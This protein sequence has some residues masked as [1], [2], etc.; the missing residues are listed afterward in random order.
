MGTADWGG[1][2]DSYPMYGRDII[3]GDWVVLEFRDHVEDGD[4]TIICHAAGC[5]ASI[6]AMEVVIDSW[7]PADEEHSEPHNRKRFAILRATLNCEPA[8]IR[9]SHGRDETEGSGVDGC[10]S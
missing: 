5:V 3:P 6:D 2:M 10:T 1:G 7:L 4:H 8:I 9:G